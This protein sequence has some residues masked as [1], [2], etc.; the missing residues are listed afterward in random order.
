MESEH[1][2]VVRDAREVLVEV[3][4]A[5]ARAELHGPGIG[6]LFAQQAAEQGRLAAAVGA[7]EAPPLAADDLQVDAGK[8]RPLEGL[9]Q[10]LGADHDV[11]APRGGR[12]A[13]RRRDDRPRHGHQ[14]DA[15]QFLPPVFGLLV[16]LAVMVAANEVLGLL[17]LDLLLL[18][19]PLR[20]EQAL[21]LLRPVG[22]EIAR[23][24]FD[25]ALEEF[26]GA[27]GHAV[28]EVTVVAHQEHRRGAFGQERFEPL[29]GLDVEVVRGLVQEHHVGLGQQQ[30]RQHEPVLLASA[31]RFDGLVERGTRLRGTRLRVAAE[32]KAVEDAFDLVVEI[33]GVAGLHLVLEVVVAIGQAFVLQR[34]VAMAQLLGDGN[35]FLLHGHEPREGALGL[36]EEGAAG[37]PLRLLLQVADVE[38]GMADD[39][40]AVGLFLAGQDPH[41][42]G[43]AGAVGPDEADPLAGAKFERHP[44]EDRLGAVVLLKAFNLEE[45]HR[46]SLDAENMEKKYGKLGRQRRLRT[47]A[48]ISV[49]FRSAKATAFAERK[50]TKRQFLICRS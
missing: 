18:V 1:V 13:H 42:R 46:V 23:I 48:E 20:D 21:G 39:Q 45:D 22:G 37:L 12:E 33:V 7:E 29:G 16:L 28:E 15:F 34:V 31:E 47:G 50:A 44:I 19:G 4:D 49:A 17:D 3:A 25:R 5:H 41:Q 35:Q 40:A 14:L 43:L 8:Q 9:G 30:L 24:A 2:L 6:L 26:Q 32:A 11:A 38:R 10:A 27:V 36:V